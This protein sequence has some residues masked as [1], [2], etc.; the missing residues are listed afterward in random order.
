MAASAAFRTRRGRRCS[1]LRRREP[2]PPPAVPALHPMQALPRKRPYQGTAG[3]SM[4]SGTRRAR[5]A[6]LAQ[7][8]SSRACRCP[9]PM[10]TQ[11]Q[12]ATPHAPPTP[13]NSKTS[14]KR[15]FPH[16]PMPS[17]PEKPPA[18]P[19][20]AR[21]QRRAA[22]RGAQRHTCVKKHGA[23]GSGGRRPAHRRTCSAASRPRRACRVRAPCGGQRRPAHTHTTQRKERSGGRQVSAESGAT[24]G[25]G[26]ASEAR[27]SRQEES[28]RLPWRPPRRAKGAHARSNAASTR[29]GAWE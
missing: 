29:T 12:A 1:P 28:P 4:H 2:P 13:G 21:E 7:R 14:T 8:A 3:T 15:P 9:P 22:E 27:A 25:A 17:P 11:G 23:R 18:A 16:S 19:A 10:A 26:G 20:E 5:R 6:R 24:E